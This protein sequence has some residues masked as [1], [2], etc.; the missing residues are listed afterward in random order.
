MKAGIKRLVIG[1][2]SVAVLAGGLTACCSTGHRSWGG[3]PGGWSDAD[4]AARQEKMVERI[5]DKLDLDADQKTKLNALADAMKEQRKALRGPA[6]DPRAEMNAVIAGTTFDRDKA[7]GMLD[8]R[9]SALQTQGPNVLD[10]MAEFYDSLT[11]EQQERVRV[12]LNKRHGWW[13]K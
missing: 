7:Q 6:D 9:V 11:P 10:K 3:G 4:M 1:F 8:Q 12:K 2:A 5:T 13:H